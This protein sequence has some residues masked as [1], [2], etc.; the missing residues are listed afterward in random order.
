[1]KPKNLKHPFKWEERHVEIRD[2]VWYV[3]DYYDAYSTFQFPG[4]ADASLFG[5]QAPVK[6]EFCSG[7]GTWIADRAA[8]DPDSNWLAV[9]WQFRRVRKIWSKVKNM[10][11]SNLVSL[12][13]EAY[14][15]TKHYIPDNSVDEIYINFPDPWP[16][17]KH[18]KHR[19]IKAPFVDEMWRILKPSG[20][21]TL[22][23]DDP[24]YSAIMIEEMLRHPG[25]TSHYPHPYYVHER[26]EYGAQSF[27]EDL[28][29][30]KGRQIHYHLFCKGDA[31][32]VS[33]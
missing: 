4:W 32:C 11:L 3:P 13:G 8:K 17:E 19:I 30:S 20:T 16:K 6:I 27:F 18:A 21:V 14:T 29:R 15:A 22:V 26:E 25:F 23:T 31:P 10:E 9:E 28:W 24:P 5:R 12:C 1:M 33:Q 7:N 2:K